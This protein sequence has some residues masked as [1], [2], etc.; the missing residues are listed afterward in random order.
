M[1]VLNPS[2]QGFRVRKGFAGV[3]MMLAAL[4]A[5]T[6]CSSAPSDSESM[7]DG[8]TE[9]EDNRDAGLYYDKLHVCIQNKTSSP[10]VLE[11][12]DWM[13]DDTHSYL[14]PEDVKK[15]LGPDAFACAFTHSTNQGQEQGAAVID[16]NNFSFWNGDL[17]TEVY[18]SSHEDTISEPNKVYV[19]ELKSPD[20][21]PFEYHVS[22][23]LKLET[24][25]KIKAYP[26]DLKLY[27]PPSS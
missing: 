27:D 15:T 9:S 8:S 1:H 16:G 13:F 2:A 18:S 17:G 20:R 4:I 3:T 26:L 19:R 23:T 10:V 7:M 5:V 11:W 21:R 25:N 24:F 6:A 12:S 22:S 14:K